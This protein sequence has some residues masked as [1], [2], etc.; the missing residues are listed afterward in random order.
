[1]FFCGS[2]EIEGQR[3]GKECGGYRRGAGIQELLAGEA[4][5]AEGGPEVEEDAGALVFQEAL[6]P[7]DLATPASPGSTA[8]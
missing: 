3:L 8:P 2:P 7:A 5:G 6:V 4:T 1:M